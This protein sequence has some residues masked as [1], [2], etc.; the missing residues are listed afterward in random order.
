MEKSMKLPEKVDVTLYVYYVPPESWEIE[1]S[2]RVTQYDK[3][4]MDSMSNYVLLGE[5]EVTI[6]VPMK[7]E[8]EITLIRVNDL[9]GSLREFNVKAELGRRN[10][11]N[12]IDDLLSLEHIKESGGE[13]HE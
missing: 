9:R 8:K 3:E 11:Q 7:S 6:D 2:V 12:Q 1:G 4:G 5:K 13:E 10:I